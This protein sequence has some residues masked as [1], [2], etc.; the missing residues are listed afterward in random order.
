MCSS[1]PPPHP[2][3][4]RQEKCLR[5]TQAKSCPKASIQLHVGEV[6]P[7]NTKRENRGHLQWEVG[8][9]SSHL[10]KVH[11]HFLASRLLFFQFILKSLGERERK[12]CSVLTPPSKLL[13]QQVSKLSL[14]IL[15][16]CPP[17]IPCSLIRPGDIILLA[18]FPA[19]S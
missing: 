19:S 18:C 11:F 16:L 6:C 13:P 15:F 3:H 1:P 5:Q 8:I 2:S 4:L 12:H 14:V 7:C 17:Q 10:E 9:Q